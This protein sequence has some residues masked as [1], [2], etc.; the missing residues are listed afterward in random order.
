MQEEAK[1][2]FIF[3]KVQHTGLRSS[4]NALKVS[5]TTGT[6]ISYTMDEN[7]FSTAISEL[8]EFI[9]KNARKFSGIQVGNGTKG[10]DGIY[11]GDGSINTGHIPNWKLLPFK[12]QKLVIDERK[13]QGIRYKGKSG[14][15]SGEHGN[16][17]H[18]AAYSNRFKQFK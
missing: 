15:K 13:Q 7:H 16:S 3:S 1:V 6:T 10:G 4:V 11:N 14:A 8:P 12:D 18:A 9:S 17:N 5:Q 2:R